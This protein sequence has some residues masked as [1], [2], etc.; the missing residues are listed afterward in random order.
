MS[1]EFVCFT[2]AQARPNSGAFLIGAL[3]G[4]TIAGAV[5]GLLPLLL[6][7]GRGQLPLGTAGMVSCM[8]SGAILGLILAIPVAVI[9]TVVVLSRGRQ[10]ARGFQP[11]F[12]Q[13]LPPAPPAPAA[14]HPQTVLTPEAGEDV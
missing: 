14:P 2:L 3:I 11:I 9:F 4:G 7:R 10:A 12:P 5:C 1:F 6:A 8:I 13:S